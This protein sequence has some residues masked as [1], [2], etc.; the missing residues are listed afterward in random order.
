VFPLLSAP[1]F[2]VLSGKAQR[3]AR[4]TSRHATAL[5]QELLRHAATFVPHKATNTSSCLRREQCVL[6]GDVFLHEPAGVFFDVI[7]GS[8]GAP[9]T[10]SAMILPLVS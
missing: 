6:P 8:I 3:W 9:R 2:A 4:A 1:G 7:S 5:P 10:F